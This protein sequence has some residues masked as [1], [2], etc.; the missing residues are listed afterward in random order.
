[1]RYRIATMAI[2]LVLLMGAAFSAVPM[3]RNAASDGGTIRRG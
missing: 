1:M 2:G 3:M